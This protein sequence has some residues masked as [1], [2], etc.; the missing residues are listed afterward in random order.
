MAKVK[1]KDMQDWLAEHTQWQNK[2]ADIKTEI[3]YL[4]DL[5]ANPIINAPTLCIAVFLL[6]SQMIEFEIKNIIISLDHIVELNLDI[7]ESKIKRKTHTHKDLDAY[8]L[9]KTIG[10]LSE[11]VHPEV[12]TEEFKNDLNDLNKLRNK[13][14][15]KLFE[16]GPTLDDIRKEAADGIKATDLVAEYINKC[17]ETI[18]KDMQS[19]VEQIIKR[20]KQEEKG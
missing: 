7:N 9:G 15:H 3:S 18:N 14:T 1:N 13:F 10:I 12:I 20:V 2:I 6:K 5:Q 8:T 19:K 17:K 16:K 4:S 11:Y